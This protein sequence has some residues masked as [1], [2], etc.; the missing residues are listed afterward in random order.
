MATT[1]TY[2]FNPSAAD[3]VLNAFGMIGVRRAQLTTEHL[4]NAGFAA[5]MIGVDFT[6]RNPNRW[7][8]ETFDFVLTPG[9]PLITLAAQVVAIGIAYID[10]DNGDGTERTQV[11]TPFSA[12]DYASQPNKTQQG[13]PTAYFFSLLTPLPTLTLWQVPPDDGVTRT[14]RV[15]AFKQ[16]QDVRLSG[17][18]TLDTP[19]RFL[20]AF[21]LGLTA[22][23]AIYYPDPTRPDLPTTMQAFYQTQFELAAAQDQERVPLRIQ[24][25]LSSYFRAG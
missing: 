9:V 25:G 21:T 7:Q 5:Q 23:L 1:G 20:D 10:T 8:M 3:V 13:V 17:G 24:P 12:T 14:L 18:Y 16:Q 19:F 6:N 4:E 22:R 2:A 11:L 15:Q